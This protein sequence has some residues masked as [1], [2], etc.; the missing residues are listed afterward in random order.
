MLCRVGPSRQQPMTTLCVCVCFAE[1][2]LFFLNNKIWTSQI[3]GI[4]QTHAKTHLLK[5]LNRGRKDFDSTC[6]VG[7][8]HHADTPRQLGHQ[9]DKKTSTNKKRQNPK[10]QTTGTDHEL[11]WQQ[12]APVCFFSGI[13]YFEITPGGWV[14]VCFCL[15]SRLRGVSVC[16][17]LKSRL[18]GPGA[19]LIEITPGGSRCICFFEITP[20]GGGFGVFCLEITF[21]GSR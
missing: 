4:K 18:G 19:F 3:D 16:F 10:I 12:R 13:T 6:S 17:F 2:R 15:K 8:T 11:N 14:Q 9:I 1:C 5:R 20:G 7:K 21:G